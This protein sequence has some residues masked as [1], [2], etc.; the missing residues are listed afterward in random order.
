[1]LKIKTKTLDGIK[2]KV[3]RSS[4]FCKIENRK[5]FRL[6]N[7]F[8]LDQ[9]QLS[10]H[11]ISPYF[12]YL[13]TCISRL[14]LAAWLNPW[15]FAFCPY[16]LSLINS[17]HLPFTS[18][19]NCAVSKTNKSCSLH[20]LSLYHNKLFLIKCLED[21]RVIWNYKPCRQPWLIL[22]IIKFLLSMVIYLLTYH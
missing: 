10:G 21:D 6:I 2:S 18:L 9:C 8:P 15:I 20:H 19:L 12:N 4:Y 11:V 16:R 22:F 17:K 13:Y 1:M 14:P 7:H 5:E 3:F